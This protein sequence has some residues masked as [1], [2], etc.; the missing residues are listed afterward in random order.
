[1]DVG[2]G[3]EGGVAVVVLAIYLDRTWLPER[4]RGGAY[5]RASKDPDNPGAARIRPAAQT[6][7]R[8][9]GPLPG[10]QLRSA[11]HDFVAEEWP[12]R[13]PGTV[14]WLRG[15]DAVGGGHAREIR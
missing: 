7:G 12:H 15:A 4:R 8:W 5:W 2:L 1:M 13:P 14:S 10:P 3:S 11:V 9:G 6:V